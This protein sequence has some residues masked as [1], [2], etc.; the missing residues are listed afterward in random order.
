MFSLEGRAWWILR[1]APVALTRIWWSKFAI[2]YVPLLLLGLILV[3]ATNFF[4]DV[5]H[6]LT[7]LFALTLI[8]LIAAIVSLG[9]AFGA[10]YPRLDTQNAAQIATGFGAIV[11][12]VL[13]LGLIG[14][15]C[16]LEAWPVTR[17]FWA[18]GR[19]HPLDATEMG[20]VA[21]CLAA[22]LVLL[23]VVFESARR[24]A[25]RRLPHI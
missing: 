13:S 2:G 8:P 3:A 10:A 24:V 12:M 16:L 11:Y 25:L 20:W 22:T 23:L 7:L 21:L 19:N 1:S 18:A 4:L 15:V 6:G 17:M 14:V 5:G 9:L